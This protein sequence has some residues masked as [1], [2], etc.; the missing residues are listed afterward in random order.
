M[1]QRP[2]TPQ[3]DYLVA[4]LRS[5]LRTGRPRAIFGTARLRAMSRYSSHLAALDWGL[6]RDFFRHRP[7]DSSQVDI[8]PEERHRSSAVEA[9]RIQLAAYLSAPV[10]KGTAGV[11]TVPLGLVESIGGCPGFEGPFPQPV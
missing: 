1:V 7:F 10:S 2:G 11:G 6:F 4:R 8:T 5:M 9:T 3:L